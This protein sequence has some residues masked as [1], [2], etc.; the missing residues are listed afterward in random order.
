MSVFLQFLS[1]FY[2]IINPILSQN[3]HLILQLLFPNIYASGSYYIGDFKDG[4]SHGKG[5]YH[6]NHGKVYKGQWE[7]GKIN[8]H[9]T[10]TYSYGIKKTG[11]WR[12]DEFL[13]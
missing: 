5:E 7:N 11:K 2:I 8:G 13:G 12:D 1:N 10:M 4:V 3:L 6:W 9:G